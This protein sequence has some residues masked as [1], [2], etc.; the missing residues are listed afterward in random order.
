MSDS[1]DWSFPEELR[2]RVQDLEFDL[3][4]AL[5]AVVELR[6]EVPDDAFTAATLGTERGGNAVVIDKDGLVLTIGYLITEAH[7][8]WLTTRAGRVAQAYPV[9][10][11]QATGFGLVKALGPLEVPPLARGSTA[12]VGRGDRVYMLSHGG[13][14][15]ALRTKISDK[16][17]FAGYWEYLLEEALFT[18]PAHPEWSGAALLDGSGRL[19]GIGSLLTQESD[20]GDT[21]QG[22]MSVPVDLLEPILGS[23]LQ[24]GQSG[25]A[26]RPWLGMYVAD[27]EGQ[28]VV[29]GVSHG[30]PAQRAGVRTDDMVLDVAGERVS[31][32]GQF[33]RAV[34]RIGPAGVPVPIT[35]ARG[36]ELLRLS[37][38]SIDRNDMLSRPQLH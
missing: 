20:D 3:V 19:I 24:T 28:L 31:S 30:G 14:R 16:R 22:N 38:R 35:L 23:L 4:A 26:A 18:S 12:E 6:A 32:L 1:N 17:E 11:D 34:W 10:Y 15:R 27:S 37:I 8:I 2:P 9:A 13:R 29:G 25:R 36:A 5:D 21:V 7:T 33:L